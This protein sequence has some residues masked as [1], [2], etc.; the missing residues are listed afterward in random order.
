MNA[1]SGPI[2]PVLSNEERDELRHL[3]YLSA[4][5]RDLRHRGL[6]PAESYEAIAADGRQRREAIERHGRYRAAMSRA[7]AL[8]QGRTAEALSW[9][10]QARQLEP[11]DAEAWALAIDLLWAMDRDDEAVAL[12]T[13]AAGHLPHLGH[14]LEVLRAQLGERAE[15]TGAPGRARSE[16]TR[17]GGATR[18]GDAWPSTIGMTTR[19]S[20][21]AARSWPSPPT[22]STPS[23][24]P[25][26]PSSGSDGWTRPS[27][28]TNASRGSSRRTGRGRSGSATWRSAGA[29]TASSG[30]KPKRPPEGVR[31]ED[32]PDDLTAPRRR[33][34]RGRASPPSSSRSTGRS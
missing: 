30:R 31:S 7:R 23:R 21:S 33:R 6:I 4:R 18:R 27:S 14:K 5:A 12:C 22:G 1:A 3:E 9:A 29:S 28:C 2:D 10:E 15:S 24:W 17:P 19:R 16:R 32:R 26:M 25:R 13:E 11:E 8:A 20:R 34:G